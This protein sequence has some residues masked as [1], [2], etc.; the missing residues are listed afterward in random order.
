VFVCRTELVQPRLET[1][2]SD[3]ER[4]GVMPRTRVRRLLLPRVWN[5]RRSLDRR[6]AGVFSRRGRVVV[7]GVVQL[8]DGQ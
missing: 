6:R 1:E 3:E 7:D 4:L 5:D 2:Q 8:V